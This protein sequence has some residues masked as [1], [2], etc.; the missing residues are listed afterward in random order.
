MAE[1]LDRFTSDIAAI[2]EKKTIKIVLYNVNVPLRLWQDEHSLN[3]VRDIIVRDLGGETQTYFQISVTYTLFNGRTGESKAGIFHPHSE[4]TGHRLFEPD[5]F[6]DFV[7]AHAQHR[8]ISEKLMSAPITQ[9]P[10]WVLQEINSI[11]ISFQCR[12][13]IQHPFFVRYR[14]LLQRPGVNFIKHFFFV[15]DDEA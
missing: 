6:T 5:S 8:R 2:D 9:G 10:A 1:K 4:V 3:R 13:S 14:Q 12:I 11:V 7:L 15:T